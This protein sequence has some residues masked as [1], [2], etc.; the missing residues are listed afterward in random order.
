L[1][2]ASTAL[3]EAHRRGP[4]TLVVFDDIKGSDKAQ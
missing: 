3:W 1:S 2:R 4:R